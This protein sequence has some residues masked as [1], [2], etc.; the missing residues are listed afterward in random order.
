VDVGTFFVAHAQASE[1]MQPGQRA[2]DDP[3]G[4]AQS[5]AVSYLAAGQKRGDAF[6]TQRVAMG[7]GIV[8]AVTLDTRRFASRASGLAVDRRDALDQGQQL[9]DVMGIGAAQR[10]GKWNALGIGEQVMFAP[11][12]PS[13]RR[14]RASFLPP[15]TARTEPL[16]TTARDQ[17]MASASRSWASSVSNTR[18]HT[19]CFCQA[20]RRRQHVMPLPQP[21]SW[22]RY[23]Q[24]MP[25]RSTNKM[26]VSVRRFATGGRPLL[27]A[28]LS[29]GKRGIVLPGIWTRG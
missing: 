24:G 6:C 19:P 14:I 5:A 18:C 16:S 27:R 11:T 10:E 7:L 28:G 1:L 29:G 26:P 2:L 3:A 15:K 23:S 25:V 9:G 4:F 17:S 21:I 22:G 13:I 8:G 12:L 20:C